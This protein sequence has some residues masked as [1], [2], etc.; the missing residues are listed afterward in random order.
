MSLNPEPEALKLRK[1][2]ERATRAVAAI[3]LGTNSSRLL[4][5]DASG[6]TLAREMK[7]T[8]LGQGVDASGALHPDAMDRTLDVLRTYRSVLDAHSVD[9]VRCFAT[10]AARDASNREEFFDRVEQVLRHR[11]ELLSGVEEGAL[12]WRGATSWVTPRRTPFNEP[13]LD[14]VIDIGGGST[15][16]VVGHPGDDPLAVTSIDMGCVRITEKFLHSDPPGP[17]ELSDAVTVM[18]SYLDDV[19]RQIPVV[20]DATNLIGVA[21]SITTVAAMDIG[22]HTYDRDRIHRFVLSRAAVEDVFRTIATEPAADRAFNP[23][24]PADRVNTIV[25]GC[26]ILAV[27]MRSFDFDACTVSETDILDAAAMSLL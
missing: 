9:A 22:L 5:V 27:I 19:K 13:A 10:S 6:A 17:M 2:A 16:F 7:V 3:D 26:L 18:H 8:R 14:L 23:G 4:V 20:R 15:E 21:G 11:P 24:L 1:H 12:S 25:G